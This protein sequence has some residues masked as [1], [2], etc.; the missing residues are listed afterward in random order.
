MSFF[1]T[2]SSEVAELIPLPYSHGR[3]IY[4]SDRLHDLS[5]TVPRYYKN[6]YVNSFFSHTVRLWNNLPVEFFPLTHDLNNFKSRVN[7]HLLSLGSF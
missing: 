4:Y 5:V 2:C 6:V 7:R 1:G 3:P